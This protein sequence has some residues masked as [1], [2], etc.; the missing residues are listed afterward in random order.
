MKTLWNILKTGLIW[1]LIIFF[2]LE[3]FLRIYDPFGF[4]VEGDKIR[5]H[6]NTRTVYKHNYPTIPPNPVSI[7][8]NL[9][10]HGRDYTP[11][12]DQMRIY[13]VG[14]STT[15]CDLISSS[16]SWP[17][18]LDSMALEQH[19]NIWINNA[20]FSGHTSFGHQI[21][22]EDIILDYQPDKILLMVG[23]NDRGLN[24]LHE[25]DTRIFKKRR[26]KD[27]ASGLG[28]IYLFLVDN[29]KVFSLINNL[30]RAA[31]A[32]ENVSNYTGFYDLNTI[33][34]TDPTPDS[35]RIK[36]LKAYQKNFIPNYE[37]RIQQFIN[38]CK[39]ND[40]QP[41]LISQPI[42]YDTIVDEQ[43]NINLASIEVPFKLGE[44]LNIATNTIDGWTEKAILDLHNEAL[45]AVAQ[46]M[47][48][49]FIDLATEM[50]K[51]FHYFYDPIHYT[52]AGCAAVAEIIFT[53][54]EAQNLLN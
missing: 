33:K 13:A 5:L 18:L 38:T 7:R 15:K 6:P 50:P 17:V 46:R 14:G 21:L 26:S 19:S 44:S 29:S 20:G 31:A 42:L 25:K 43:T 24:N 40:I 30:K 2:I 27:Q 32:S 16:V 35:I 48:V 36:I 8:N 51:S 47:E 23:A 1:G 4:T 3:V 12:A 28:K 54:L 39:Q 10:F 52:E 41:I 53:A 37:A 11:E 45:K 22:L 9:G 49:P 34:T